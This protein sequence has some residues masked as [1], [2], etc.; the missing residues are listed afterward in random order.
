MSPS[1]FYQVLIQCKSFPTYIT[2]EGFKVYV[3]SVVS[4]ERAQYFEVLLADRTFETCP[5]GPHQQLSKDKRRW[6]SQS[7]VRRVILVHKCFGDVRVRR[8]IGTAAAAITKITTGAA[9]FMAPAVLIVI[10]ANILF[11]GIANGFIVC[12]GA[13]W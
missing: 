3:T 11:R 10:H 1:M 7:C 8:V 4:L 13:R 12:V 6:A 2:C 5:P 9:T